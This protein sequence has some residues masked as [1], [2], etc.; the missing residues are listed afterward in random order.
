MW[1]GFALA[2]AVYTAALTA[3][4]L[5]FSRRPE[6]LEGF[7]LAGR[8]LG[9]LRL[10]LTLAASWIGAASLL[11]S[12]DE[13][14]RDGLSASWVIGLPAVSTLV[15]FFGLARAIR[16]RSGPTLPGLMERAYGRAARTLTAVLVVWY[17]TVLAASQ[18]AAAG[19]Y[20]AAILG[21]PPLLG[22]AAATALV[23][24]YSALGGLVSVARAHVLQVGLLA[25]G[26]AG[27][28]S[29]LASRSSWEAVRTTAAELGKTGYFSFLASADRH[30]LIAVSFILAWTISPVAW[31]R[32]Q[33]AQSDRSARRGLV[34]AALIL[35]FFYA[36]I[37]V[38]GML[39]L[40]L[41][42]GAG[43]DLPLVTTFIL[44]ESGTFLSGLLFIAVL[45]ALLS[46]MDA[47]LNSGAFVL[48][49][50]LGRRREET[51]N[52]RREVLTAKTTTIAL[53]AGAFLVAAR[54]SDILKTLGLASKI[55]AEGLFIPGLAALFLKRKAPLAGLL[56]M[57]GGGSFALACFLEETGLLRLGLPAWPWS[58]PLGLALGAAGFAAGLLLDISRE[59]D[60]R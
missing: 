31:Q 44:D 46:T 17:M 60:K 2:A 13:A 19:P 10:A 49:G 47:A 45:A 12:T 28:S 11:V 25:A 36:G 55:M 26:V 33:A 30:V 20:L 4:A 5:A 23:L 18:M 37:V 8:R 38:A 42:P 1:T 24:L 29:V 54:L 34:G 53:A 14:H 3:A 6:G 58:L 32:I 21:T 51:S 35:A 59:M 22:L 56:A 41:F 9:G 50:E 43:R 40:P 7:F 27:M 39:A 57:G 16:S 15:V 48:V 52:A